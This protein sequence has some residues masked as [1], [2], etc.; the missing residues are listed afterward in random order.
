MADRYNVLQSGFMCVENPKLI[1]PTDQSSDLE[2]DAYILN[3]PYK[4]DSN[5]YFFHSGVN[6]CY[7]DYKLNQRLSLDFNF[8]EKSILEFLDALG[9]PSLADW[10]LI[11][12]NNPHLS[13]LDKRF[14]LD[15]LKFIISGKRDIQPESWDLLIDK[16][17]PYNKTP[18]TPIDIAKYFKPGNSFD[19]DKV[20]FNIVDTLQ[21]WLS[22]NMG[23]SDFIVTI[24][25]IFGRRTGTKSL[26]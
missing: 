7:N 22:M 8:R 25:I 6:T 18:S 11:Q 1:R 19:K 24:G 17:N 14:L 3:K 13:E 12:N 15:M 4:V 26:S 10:I 16:S 20:S 21:E 9:V 23:F 2:F 5:I